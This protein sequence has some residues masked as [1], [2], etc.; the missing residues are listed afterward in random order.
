MRWVWLDRILELVEGERCVAVRAVSHG[1]DVLHDHI[2]ALPPGAGRP[3]RPA[4][5]LMPHSLIVEGMAQC[6]G[7][8]TGHARDFREKVILAKVSKADFH[9]P[10]AVP[11]TVLRHTA[12][13]QRIDD[14]G[15]AVS[16][17]VELLQPGTGAEPL[18][19]ADMEMMFS[20]VDRNQAGTV[21]PERN[22]VFTEQFTEL[23]VRSGVMTAEKAAEVAAR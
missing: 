20:H 19:M 8:L 18:P 5:P 16:G 6:G 12:S 3:G 23:L 2:P 13:L 15:S 11:G 4:L 22:F 17:T 9:G 1:E 10:L 21:F 7:I 14:L